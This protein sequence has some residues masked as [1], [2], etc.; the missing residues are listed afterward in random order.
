MARVKNNP[1]LKGVR[2]SIDRLVIKQYSYGTVITKKPDMS[3]V[4]PSKLQKLKQSLFKA[5]VAYA[6][7]INR[8]PKKKA[9][10]AKKLKPGKTV[11]NTAVSEYMKRSKKI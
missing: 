1:L 6:Q 9:A 2:G 7:S 8:D 3:K 5:A 11:F 10:F 4:K